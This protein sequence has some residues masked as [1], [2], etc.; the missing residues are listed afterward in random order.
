MSGDFWGGDEG[1][2]G[3][4]VDLGCGDEADMAVD[5]GSGIPAG[6]GLL[7]V[8]DADGDDVFAGVKV[9]REVVVEADVAVGAVAEK[10]SVAVDVGVGH[11]AVKG[12]VSAFRRVEFWQRE[13]MTVPGDAGGEEAAGCAR[14]RVL[15]YGTGD[16]PVVGEGDGLP[17][18]IIEGGG[19]SV[20]GVG[21][22][23][24]PVGVE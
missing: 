14:G 21:L 16:A 3:G 6:G 19:F 12:D 7:A 23:E 18:G 15:A 2:P 9:R 4:Y 17:L 10:F 13:R 11:D 8:V 24:A 20:G 1:A 5:A 22:G